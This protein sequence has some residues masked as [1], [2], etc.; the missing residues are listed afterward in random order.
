M[1]KNIPRIVPTCVDTPTSRDCWV[2]DKPHK[3]EPPVRTDIVNPP[4]HYNQS[5]IV[6]SQDPL[7]T[8]IKN[9][10]P[11]VYIYAGILIWVILVL[12]IRFTIW[13]WTLRIE[14]REFRKGMLVADK[15]DR[16]N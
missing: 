9:M 1:A 14:G 2:G 12:V 11:I 15:E 3:F 10:H 5:L 7:G 4:Q 8:Y 6:P 13:K 16:G